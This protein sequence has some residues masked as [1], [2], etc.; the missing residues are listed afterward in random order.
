MIRTNKG[1][2]V[3]DFG[4]ASVKVIHDTQREA[5][6]CEIISILQGERLPIMCRETRVYLEE[7]VKDDEAETEYQIIAVY[8]LLGSGG[9]YSHYIMDGESGGIIE[10]GLEVRGIFFC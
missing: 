7:A 2:P 9:A 1:S 3:K 10:E 6:K 5:W 8:I 4:A